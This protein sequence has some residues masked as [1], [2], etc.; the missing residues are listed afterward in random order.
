MTLKNEMMDTV[1]EYK[2]IVDTMERQ[3]RISRELESPEPAVTKPGPQARGSSVGRS[4]DRFNSFGEQM[5]AVMRAGM[6]GG[7]VDPRLRV[8]AAATGLGET[9][10]SDGGFLVQTDFSNELLQEVFATG[11]LA[12]RCRRIQISG[13]ANSI[14]INGVDE[15]SRAST[16]SGGIVGYWKDEAASK[17]ASKPKFRQIELSLKKLIG[18]CYAIV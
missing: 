18:L 8:Q 3:E 13:N 12:P 5:A 15:T 1:K 4:Q 6:S 14:K 9:I 11:I 16:R 17:T 7:T 2:H 10:S